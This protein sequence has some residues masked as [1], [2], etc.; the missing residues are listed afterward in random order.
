VPPACSTCGT[1]ADIDAVMIRTARRPIP[2]GKISRA[3]ALVFGLVRFQ[4]SGARAGGAQLCRGREHRYCHRRR[5]RHWRGAGRRAKPHGRVAAGYGKVD[6]RSRLRLT[7]LETGPRIL[8]AF[9][10]AVSASATSQLRMLG[11][12]VRTGVKVPMPGDISSTVASI[13]QPR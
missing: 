1:D 8:S 7:L 5:R 12:D 10:E 13:S 11:V 3:D 4:R 6:I 2:R 9:P